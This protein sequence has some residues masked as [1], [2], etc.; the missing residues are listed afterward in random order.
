MKIFPV[1]RK[2]MPYH[3]ANTTAHAAMRHRNDMKYGPEALSAD[4]KYTTEY[5]SLLHSMGEEFLLPRGKVLRENHI[6]YLQEGRCAL[7]VYGQ[8]GETSTLI[9]FEPGRLL[10][11]LPSLSRLYPLHPM[12]RRRSVPRK[13]FAVRALTNCRFLRVRHEIFI[14]A[15]ADSLPLHSLMVRSLTEN[16]L[17]LLTHAFNSPLLPAGQRICRLLA[18]IMD[19]QPPHA[20]PRYM[21]Y[22]EISTHLSIHPITVAKIFKTLRE[23]RIIRKKDAGLTVPMSTGCTASLEAW[24]N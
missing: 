15:F 3:N 9:Y 24:K 13:F 12:T 20:L 22:P 14:K 23:K 19:D 2:N 1:W 11:F 8:C 5:E 7:C 6:Y 18:D 21:T 17:N 4:T 10:N 16:I